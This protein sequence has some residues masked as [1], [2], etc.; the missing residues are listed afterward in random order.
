MQFDLHFTASIWRIC[1]RGV[2]EGVGEGER[3]DIVQGDARG[4]YDCGCEE[5]EGRGGDEEGVRNGFN[6]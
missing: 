5:A 1:L 3:G 4:R 2:G 6:R